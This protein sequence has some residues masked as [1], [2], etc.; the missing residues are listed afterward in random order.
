LQ[1]PFVFLDKKWKEWIMSVN[2][3]QGNET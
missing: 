2:Q 1:T 3:G